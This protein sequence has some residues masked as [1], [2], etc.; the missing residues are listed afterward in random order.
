VE[1]LDREVL[2]A[3]A[4]HLLLL[5]LQDLARP[6]VRIDDVVPDLV[7]DVGRLSGD[8]EVREILLNRRFGN[9]VPS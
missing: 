1:D 6:V 9:D 3:L 2:A 5:L 7:L 8:L 4:E